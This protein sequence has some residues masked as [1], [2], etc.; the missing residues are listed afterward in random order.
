MREDAVQGTQDIGGVY[1]VMIR[2]VH[3]P[4]LYLAEEASETDL[5]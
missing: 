3:I 2:V 4:F 5:A 1:A